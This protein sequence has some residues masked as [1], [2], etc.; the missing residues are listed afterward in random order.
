MKLTFGLTCPSC[1]GRMEI[2]EGEKIAVCPFCHTVSI[3]EGE[4]GVKTLSYKMK[5]DEKN[6]VKKAFEWFSHGFK[7]RDLKKLAKIK[8]VYPVYLPYWKYSARGMGIVLGYNVETYVDA[9]GN[10]HRKKKRK[11]EM[12]NRDYDWTSL[13]CDAGDIGILRLRNLKGEIV[14]LQDDLPIYEATQ[15][16]DDAKMR[17]E[18][19]IKNWVLSE[20]NVENITFSKLFVIPKNFS[21]I[22]YPFWIIRYDYKGKMY[23]LTVDGVTGEVVSGRAPGDVLWQSM[24]IGGG[25]TIGGALAGLIALGGRIGVLSFIIGII[26]FLSSYMFFRHGSEIVEGDIEKPYE[27]KMVK[28]IFNNLIR[29]VRI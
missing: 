12:I 14:P 2:E 7:A 24:A 5:V 26:I 18:R 9:N 28:D 29:G 13:A 16:K 10:T 27:A 17:G 4:D 21:L 11:E 6:A 15:S 23:F 1:G 19:D 22:Y 20:A 8:E 3:I 25:A